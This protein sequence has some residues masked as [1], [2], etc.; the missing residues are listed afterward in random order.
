MG[1]HTYLRLL[2]LERH[3]PQVSHLTWAL[4][5]EQ[6]NSQI[7][8]S[9]PFSVHHL[10]D[11]QIS[12]TLTHWAFWKQFSILVKGLPFPPT[13]AGPAWSQS[14]QSNDPSTDMEAELQ[15]VST[16]G[17]RPSAPLVEIIKWFFLSWECRVRQN[18]HGG[19]L[20]VYVFVVL[21]GMKSLVCVGWGRFWVG[22][23]TSRGLSGL[24]V[25]VS[26]CPLHLCLC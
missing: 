8:R 22:C 20:W 13:S 9:W 16:R 6:A 19:W 3:F 10:L 14:K 25:G 4:H 1:P 23:C 7:V 5:L 18:Q 11:C 12:G 2:N 24:R 17:W 26:P 15:G 21:R